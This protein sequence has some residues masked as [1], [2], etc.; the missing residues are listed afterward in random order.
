YS[1]MYYTAPELEQQFPRIAVTFVLLHRVFHSLFGEAVFQ[2]EGGYGK[3][4]DEQAKVERKLGL[5]AAI[6]ELTSDAEPVGSETL[7]RPGVARRGRA[8]EEIEVVR[9]MA[10]AAA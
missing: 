10:D 1:E 8:I 2:L 6:L 4:V 3:T 7:C 9:A 5:V